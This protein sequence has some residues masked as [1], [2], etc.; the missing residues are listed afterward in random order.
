MLPLSK[1]RGFWDYG[2]F[3]LAMTG[4]LLFLFWSD[5]S[6]GIRWADATFAFAVAVSSVFAIMLSRRREKA[7]WI[8]QPTWLV[9]SLAALGSIA[10]MSGAAYAD[11][12]LLH[13]GKV[14]SGKLSD[15]LLYAII[16]TS[17]MLWSSRKR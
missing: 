4:L 16:F 17:V 14:N 10:L 5:A 7:K 11:A 1:P 12:Y 2:L 6:D 13:R 15:D 3:A 8:P 9:Y